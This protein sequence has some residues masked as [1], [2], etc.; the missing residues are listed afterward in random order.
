MKSGLISGVRTIYQREAWVT[1]IFSWVKNLVANF[2]SQGVSTCA[3]LCVT[4]LK[5][6][7]VRGQV[8]PF[9]NI[10]IRLKEKE[11]LGLYEYFGEQML[12][13]DRYIYC[14]LV[15]H[16]IYYAENKDPA[17]IQAMEQ[18]A[19]QI[20]KDNGYEI[21]A[22]EDGM[23]TMTIDRGVLENEAGFTVLLNR[24][25]ENAIKMQADMEK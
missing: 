3:S 15:V 24:L 19:R 18:R 10:P 16:S 4:S 9:I 2:R 8:F 14:D 20:F 12:L 5:N 23:A 11:L 17:H 21:I 25:L 1:G 13:D 22:F 7:Y 6:S